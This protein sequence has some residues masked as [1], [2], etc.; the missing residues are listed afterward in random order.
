MWVGQYC[1]FQFGGGVGEFVEY[2]YVVVVF[3]ILGGDEFFGYQVEFVVQWGDLYYLCGGVV[4]Y[5]FFE[6]QC[7]GEEVYWC[8]VQL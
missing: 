1:V 5:Y 8:L 2:Q 3:D 7:L 4:C 6:W